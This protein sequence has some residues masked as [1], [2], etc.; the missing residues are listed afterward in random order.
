M[1]NY[2]YEWS[3]KSLKVTDS[4][5]VQNIVVQTYWTVE[6]TDADGYKG[7]Y[8]GATPFQ[9]SEFDSVNYVPFEQLTE[10][11]VLGWIKNVVN[12]LYHYPSLIDSKIE[13]QINRQKGVVR[14]VPLPWQ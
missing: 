14:E 10:E 13:Q 1:A 5:S 4:G 7:I 9:L 3:L 11:I 2:T 6:G 8:Q 12:N